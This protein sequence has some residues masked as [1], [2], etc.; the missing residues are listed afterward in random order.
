MATAASTKLLDR[1]FAILRL[2]LT[3]RAEWS[4][5]EVT[6]AVSLPKPTV[7]RLLGVLCAHEMLVRAGD[8]YRLGP[9]AR[10]L[11]GRAVS[12]HALR[13]L[14]Q[15]ILTALAAR[16]GETALLFELAPSRDAAIC[17]EQI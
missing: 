17:I 10:A 16:T 13:Q 11:G 2:F 3:E 7:H 8:G 1:T 6:A 9:L 12:R 15:P 4:L 5:A 14:G